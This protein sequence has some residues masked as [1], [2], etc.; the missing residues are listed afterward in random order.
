M[1]LYSVFNTLE[2]KCLD[3]QSRMCEET[4]TSEKRRL[5]TSTFQ[6]GSLDSVTVEFPNNKRMFLYTLWIIL[7]YPKRPLEWN[8]VIKMDLEDIIRQSEIWLS[9]RTSSNWKTQTLIELNMLQD[10]GYNLKTFYSI[11]GQPNFLENLGK[12]RVNVRQKNN[13][14]VK[15]PLRKRGYNDKGTLRPK[16]LST[17]WLESETI[18]YILEQKRMEER[19]L[20]T[21]RDIH[22]GWIE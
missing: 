20:K 3:L 16:H 8:S 21:L 14:P 7:S 5:I 12:I 6:K 11:V 9:I 4:W 15:K 1:N 17:K 2:V 22:T 18:D 10:P 13:A 19:T